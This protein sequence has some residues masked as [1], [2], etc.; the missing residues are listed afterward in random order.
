[1]R[2]PW[3]QDRRAPEL[4]RAA[5][6]IEPDWEGVAV[7]D[8]RDPEARLPDLAQ[9]RVPAA[10]AKPFGIAIAMVGNTAA[11]L[12]FAGLGGFTIFGAHGLTKQHDGKLLGERGPRH[13]QVLREHFHN[14]RS[15]S[16]AVP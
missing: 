1:M 3:E 5:A 14:V 15:A 7:R 4:E 10:T 13:H 9:Y 8:G 6:P 12:I 11:W 16:E 2:Q